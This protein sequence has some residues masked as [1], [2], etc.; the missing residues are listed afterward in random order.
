MNKKLK[1]EINL[2]IKSISKLAQT[3]LSL[4]KVVLRDLKNNIYK[5]SLE[6]PDITITDIHNR[7]GTP[8][9][10]SKSFNNLSSDILIKKAKRYKK[11]WIIVSVMIII[12][13]IF[14]GILVTSYLSNV[15]ITD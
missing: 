7:F 9:E 4:K 12:L 13:I 11:L 10:I 15:S 14:T 1:K 8:E 3:R 2:Y 5:C 6:N